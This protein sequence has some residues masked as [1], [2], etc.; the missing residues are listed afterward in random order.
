MTWWADILGEAQGALLDALDGPR[1][2]RVRAW[3]AQRGLAPLLGRES[4]AGLAGIAD[5]VFQKSSDPDP[6]DP[7]DERPGVPMFELADPD[8]PGGDPAAERAV[9]VGLYD[10][11]RLPAAGLRRS[12]LVEVDPG[13]PVPP[14]QVAGPHSLLFPPRLALEEVAGPAEIWSQGAPWHEPVD[15]LAL[16]AADPAGRWGLLRAAMVRLGEGSLD[17]GPGLAQGGRP[18]SQ[19]RGE[20]RLAQHPLAWLQ[21]VAQLPAAAPADVFAPAPLCLLRRMD[22]ETLAL[23]RAARVVVCDGRDHAAALNRQ[24]RGARRR[25]IE[26]LAK[27]PALEF[28]A[29]QSEEVAA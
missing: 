21:A 25:F 26:R 7:G 20:L 18:D 17:P 1:G 10:I 29:E 5:V 11:E 19:S 8:A 9:L 27:L 15:L 28:E 14:E 4:R 24:L 2:A 23:G 16:S 3:F 12:A 6:E 22:F 13:D